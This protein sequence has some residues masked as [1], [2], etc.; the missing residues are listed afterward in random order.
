MERLSQVDTY[1]FR[2]INS[3]D[4]RI[5]MGVIAQELEKI[6]PELVYTADDEMGTKSV[7]YIG[8]IAP[9]IEVAKELQSENKRLQ[10]AMLEKDERLLAI[11]ARMVA[12]ESDMKGMKAHTGFGIHKASMSFVVIFILILAGGVT[13]VIRRKKRLH[14]EQKR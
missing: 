11:E 13:T 8:F 7:N 9:L 6:F 10:I 12:F 1:S 3:V 5:E 4:D 2:M 14:L